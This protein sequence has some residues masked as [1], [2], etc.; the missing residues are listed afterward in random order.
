MSVAGTGLQPG[1]SSRVRACVPGAQALGFPRRVI[2]RE[3]DTLELDPRP[4][5]GVSIVGNGSKKYS[6]VLACA[7]S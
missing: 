5:W 7:F 2:S 4:G 1:A 3:L 6:T